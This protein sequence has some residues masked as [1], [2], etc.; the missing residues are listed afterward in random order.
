MNIIYIDHYAGSDY[1]GMEFR[2]YYLSKEWHKM[3]HNVTIIAADY[4]HL[5]KNN[6]TIAQDWEE[7]RIEGIAYNWVKISRY[8]GNGIKRILSI[9]QFVTKISLHAKDIAHK[10]KPDVVICSSTY[11]F[12]TYAG[13]RIKKYSRAKL[14]HEVHD[15]W[16]LTPMELGGY[17]KYHPF[18]RIM[19]RAE[20]SAYKKSSLIVSVLP[21]IKP[22][23]ESLNINKRI[24]N[25]PNG[26]LLQ[27]E[28]TFSPA[29]PTIL[30]KINILKS[31]NHFII[32]YAGGIS[33][34]NAMWTL[35]ETAC[36]VKDRKI[37]FVIIGNGIEKDQ[38]IQFKE[39]NALG[40]VYFFEAIDKS[41][42][43]NTLLAMDALYLG[44]KKSKL[45]E[46]GVSAN[47]IFDYMLTGKPIINA[48][49]S[50]H[51]PLSYFGDSFVAE[52][53]N[54]IALKEAIDRVIMLSS[55]ELQQLE[56][57]SIEY[58][59]KNYNYPKLADD[60]AREFQQ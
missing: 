44:S 59:K 23:V 17:S 47:K 28:A 35:L 13:Q 53:E 11:P 8:E 36:L 16:P 56:A 5:R 38:L 58:V 25:I 12:D 21:N 51:S 55:V 42:I 10:Y 34:S 14:I 24:V 20:K 31:A 48:F 2:P 60:F 6:P 40:N 22:Y 26:I 4:S 19:Q 9:L 43:H 39:K 50:N 45:Y 30:E 32:G 3:G 29:N 15:L 7:S 1:H 57:K 18:I 27:D 33:V 49:D 46:F 54:A 41:E 37:S 52:A